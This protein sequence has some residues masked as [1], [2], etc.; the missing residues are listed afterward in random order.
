[1]RKIHVIGNQLSFR[2][3]HHPIRVFQNDL[4]DLGL[5]V[6]FFTRVDAPGIYACDILIF[7][8]DNYRD[9]LPIEHKD[10]NSALNFLQFLFQEI[11]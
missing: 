9:M 5:E 2:D 7:H 6:K 1:M 4:L 10:R 11:S 3:Y 8:E